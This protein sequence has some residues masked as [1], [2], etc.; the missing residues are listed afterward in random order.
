MSKT[1]P[2]ILASVRDVA[3]RVIHNSELGAQHG[4][5]DC[6][7]PR[8]RH[9]TYDFTRLSLRNVFPER[10]GSLCNLR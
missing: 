2:F 8:P 1:P 3:S 4:D 5:W 10:V 7:A 6:V 9:L